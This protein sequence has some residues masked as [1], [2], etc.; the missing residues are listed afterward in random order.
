MEV[1]EERAVLPD[2]A[3]GA[4]LAVVGEVRH[5]VAQLADHIR[6]HMSNKF[7]IFAFFF[8]L[9][10]LFFHLFFSSSSIYIFLVWICI[11]KARVKGEM[12]G[13]LARGEAERGG[14]WVWGQSMRGGVEDL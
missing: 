9:S 8:H 5:R 11:G 13:T 3:E 4:L 1:R 10:F 12:S 2:E 7:I 14:H 6:I